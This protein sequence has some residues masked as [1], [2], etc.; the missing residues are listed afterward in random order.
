MVV[1]LER[2]KALAAARAVQEVQDGMV[3]G[4]GTGSTTGYAIRGLGRRV[5][6]EGLR[7]TAIATS[8]A[9]RRL[10]ESVGI[11]IKAFDTIPQL[12]L[13]IDGADE[14]DS[15]LCAIKGG[16]GALLREK[17]A[18]AA[19]N[20]TIIIVDSSKP[21]AK[22]G[23][24]SLPVEVLPFAGAFARKQLLQFGVPVAIR[25]APDGAPFVTDQGNFICTIAFGVIE[26]PQSTAKK[27]DSIPGVLEHG[28]FL[29]EIDEVFIARGDQIE[30][31][32]RNY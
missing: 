6:E 31:L 7:I 2:E 29:S 16:G 3:V 8:E 5:K 25:L 10:A 32:R 13:A 22:L 18:A 21:V 4:L 28:L 23:R 12:D 15:S 19:A 24:F 27:I 26:D 1:D 20:R 30:I 14:V 11:D 9:S 17:I